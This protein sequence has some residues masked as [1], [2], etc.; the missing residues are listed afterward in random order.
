MSDERMTITPCIFQMKKIIVLMV[1]LALCACDSSDEDS[2]NEAYVTLYNAS[3]NAPAIYLTI[4]DDLETSDDDDIEITYR[5]IEYGQALGNNILAA[6]EYFFELAWQD[7]DSTA[8]DDLAI[9]YQDNIEIINDANQFIVI[10]EGVLTPSVMIYSI[11]L[12]DDSDDVTYDLFNLRVLNMHSNDEGIDVYLSKSDET[13][14]E[15][16]LIGQYNYQQLSDNYKYDQDSYIFYITQSGQDEVLFQSNE[17]NYSYRGQYTMIVRKNNGAGSSPYIL[18]KVSSSSVESFIDYNAEAQFNIYNAVQQHYLLP[19]Y[20]NELAVHVNGVDDSP[21]ITS[22]TLGELSPGIT[23]DKGD[24][25]LD[26][27]SAVQGSSLLANHLLSLSENS[28]KTVF[29]YVDEVDVDNDNDGNVDE[30]GDGVVDEI[31][32][33]LHSLVI[34]NSMRE[35]IYDHEIKMVNL[36]DNDDFEY[37]NIYFVRSDETIETALYQ[38]S[39]SYRSSESISLA[40]NTYQIYVVAKVNS[41]EILLN[42]FE[43]ILDESS[44]EQFLVLEVD[45][46]QPTGYRVNLLNQANALVE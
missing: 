6:D 13:F 20:E 28:Y 11:P 5:G 33:N 22:L 41:S 31:E 40:N 4:D 42:T 39:V 9:I 23:L 37:V 35:S 19:D 12:I 45:D 46:L 2:D 29:F 10:S 24:Y 44:V 27:L 1:L 7:E 16:Q 15:A 34:N 25:S 32:V 14:N 38:R 21:E 18:D 36:V 26:V 3:E 30:D 43:L 17:V 8:R